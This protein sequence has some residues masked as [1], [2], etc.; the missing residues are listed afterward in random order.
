MILSDL[1]SLT[2][3]HNQAVIINVGTRQVTTLALLSALRHAQMP[4]L[5]IDCES[6]DGS[7]DYFTRLM[8]DRPFDMLSAPLRQHGETLNWLFR[9]INCDNLLLIDSDLEILNGDIVRWMARL[10]E[11]SHV[12]GAGFTHGPCWLHDNPGVGYYQERMWMPITLLKTVCVRQAL[13][14][15]HSFSAMVRNN[16]FF[17]SRLV[18]NRLAKRFNNPRTRSLRLSWLDAFKTSYFGQ[19]PCYV[20]CDT[21]ANVFQHLK[22]QMGLH[23]AG[24]PAEV[25][26]GDVTHFHG[27]T[28]A[29][30]NPDDP[31][32][33][34]MEEITGTIRNRLRN[35]YGFDAERRQ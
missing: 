34:S 12:F 3:S 30:L 5:L 20:F 33:T 22:Y 1:K 35:E 17:P 28:R 19:K 7:W 14:K 18:S 9:N 11:Q 16:D 21:G 6:K 24:F 27:V 15:G 4:V 31:I 29:V 25:Q 23:F 2:A 10:I 32:A 13:E 8:E 26:M